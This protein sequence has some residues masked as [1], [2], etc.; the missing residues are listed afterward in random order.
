MCKGAN[1]HDN[2]LVVRCAALRAMWHQFTAIGN[3]FAREGHRILLAA[4]GQMVCDRILDDAHQTARRIVGPYLKFM[5]QLHHKASKAFKRARYACLWIDLNKHIVLGAD[6]HLQQAGAIQRR[7]EQHQQALVGD[8]GAAGARVSLIFAH[9]ARVVI[10]VE[11][12]ECVVHLQQACAI[13]KC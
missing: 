7:V 4:N 9:D 12:L 13:A 1:D 5:Q 8:V 6:E 3:Q 10:A 2:G 11:Q